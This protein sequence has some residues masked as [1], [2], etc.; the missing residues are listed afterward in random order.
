MITNN[1]SC[2]YP[3]IDVDHNMIFSKTKIDP[4]KIKYASI[5]EFST[6]YYGRVIGGDWDKLEKLFDKLYVYS[7]FKDRFIEGKKW[8][9][10]EYYK[11]VLWLR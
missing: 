8:E 4:E 10:T 11:K 2:D 7:A 1:F 9:T 3:C 6:K 5:K